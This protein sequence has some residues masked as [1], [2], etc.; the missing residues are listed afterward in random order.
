MTATDIRRAALWL[1]AQARATGLRQAAHLTDRRHRP[2]RI[3][4]LPR[5]TCGRWVSSMPTNDAKPNTTAPARAKHES[6]SR[7]PQSGRGRRTPAE[8]G[9]QGLGAWPRWMH[10]AGQEGWDA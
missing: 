3:V 5:D 7:L 1:R 8:W 6:A 9:E 10:N 4:T 2:R